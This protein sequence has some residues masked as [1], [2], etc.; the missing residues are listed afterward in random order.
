MA[1]ESG[2]Q[3]ADP[4]RHQKSPVRILSLLE[5]ARLP[6]F[7]FFSTSYPDLDV[8]RHTKM[9]R[10]DELAAVVTGGRRRIGKGIALPLQR[11]GRSLLALNFNNLQVL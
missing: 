4:V 2:R 7:I 8:L 10:N 5:M 3:R 1:D 11:T 9:R 6:L